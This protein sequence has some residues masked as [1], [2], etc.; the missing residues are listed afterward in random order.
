MKKTKLLVFITMIILE[1]SVFKVSSAWA[2]NWHHEQS[3]HGAGFSYDFIV[4]LDKTT[5]SAG[6][7]ITVT[8]TLINNQAY[9]NQ[10]AQIYIS[11]NINGQQKRL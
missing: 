1:M 10:C 8:G 9:T 6:E 5:Y 11:A 4:N 2:A 3:Y 7:T